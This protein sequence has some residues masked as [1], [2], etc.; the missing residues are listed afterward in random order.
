MTGKKQTGGKINLF[1]IFTFLKV[2]DTWHSIAPFGHIL[3]DSISYLNNLS[4]M[5]V[6]I[7]NLKY[8]KSTKNLL[9]KLIWSERL[10]FFPK[11]Y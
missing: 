7:V 10:I 8:K 9:L 6:T 4:M 1:K 5:S 11:A 3:I 2:A